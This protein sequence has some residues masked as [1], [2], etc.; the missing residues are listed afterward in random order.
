M[1]KVKTKSDFS[2]F[3]EIKKKLLDIES[4][5]IKTGFWPE[6]K[7]PNGKLNS[8][9]LANILINGARKGRSGEIPPRPFLQDGIA[10]GIL[11]LKRTSVRQYKRFMSIKNKR[12][13][14]HFAK[15]I[16]DSSS[17][18]VKQ[19]ILFN[20]YEENASYTVR[21]KGF[22][23]PLYES[24]WLANNVQTKIGRK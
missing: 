6:V 5:S 1:I 23:R 7:H 17:G 18:W 13:F 3:K 22:N 14:K 11:D 19:R 10:D 21:R 8:A 4:T 2:G 24:G 12:S 20:S 15:P 9:E 16:A